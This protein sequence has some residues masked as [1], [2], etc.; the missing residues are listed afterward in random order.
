METSTSTGKNRLTEKTE[1][2]E[3]TPVTLPLCSAK[4]SYELAQDKSRVFA[5]SD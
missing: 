1:V 4:I 2:L 5:N 3:E